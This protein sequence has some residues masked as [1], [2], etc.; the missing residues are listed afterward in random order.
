MF[1]RTFAIDTNSV[2]SIGN[3]AFQNCSS[4]TSI[5]IPNS[6]TSIGNYAFASC[7]TIEDVYCFAETVPSTNASAFI[8]SNNQSATLHV[9]EG[10]VSDYESTAPWSQFGNILGFT[11]EKCATPTITYANGKIRFACETEDVV[12]V[13]TVTC[14]ASQL[15]NGNA[16]DIG[17]TF[18]VSVYA[19]KKGYD[20]SVVATKTITINKMGDLDGDGEL[21]VTDITSLV[22]AILGK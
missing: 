5:T 21:S 14:T 8:Y 17:G 10:S 3:Y 9:P 15:Q 11:P 13:P 20:N 18:T 19:K 16:L 1:F 6:V 7:R 4:P 2:T 12:F 22:N